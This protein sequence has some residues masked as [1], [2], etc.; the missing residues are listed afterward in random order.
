VVGRADGKSP[1]VL[2]IEDDAGILELYREVLQDE[3]CRV[4]AVTSPDLDPAAV[5]SRNPDLV[6]LDLRFRYDAC[7]VDWLGRLKASSETRH[8]PVLVCSADHRLLGRL[9]DQLLAWE[10]GVLP[11]PFGLEEFL[12]AIHAGVAPLL[13]GTGLDELHAP[14][15]STQARGGLSRAAPATL[16]G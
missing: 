12:A 2:V 5:A 6:L 1:H 14:A 7:G 4:T 9:H 11:K 15:D 8:V 10:C 3:G 16:G 13:R